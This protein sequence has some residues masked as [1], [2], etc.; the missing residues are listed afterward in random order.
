M[1]SIYDRTD[2]YDLFE[3]EG[4]YQATKKHWETVL[5]GRL[6]TSGGISSTA[7]SALDVSI[8][9]GSLTLPLAELGFALYGSDLSPSM[10]EKCKENAHTKHLEIHLRQ[11]DFRMLRPHFTGK[12]NGKSFDL[13]MSTGNSLPYVRNDELLDVL[14]EM[15]T[16]VSPGGYLYVDLRNWDKIMKE[17]NRFYLY[18]PVFRIHPETQEEE[19]INLTQVWDYHEEGSVRFHLLYTFETERKIHRREIFEERYY[20]VEQKVLLDKIREMGYS[21]IEIGRLPAQFGKF[22]LER[23]DWYYIIAKKSD[24]EKAVR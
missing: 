18:N 15:D 21:E 13:V 20:P 22:D 12:K 8:G 4:K 1:G 7:Y 23:D 14:E 6:L 2:I 10:L 24:K 9:T 11:C 16:L 5:E 19:R 3:S 17:R